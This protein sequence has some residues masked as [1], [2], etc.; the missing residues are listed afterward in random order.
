M[1]RSIARGSPGTIWRRIYSI[2]NPAAGV[3]ITVP[4]PPHRAWQL[5][6]VSVTLTASASAGNR[7]PALTLR[8]A[9]NVTLAQIVSPTAITATLA[10]RVSWVT[11]LGAANVVAASFATLTLP[12]PCYMLSAESLTI[13]GHTDAGDT[14]TNCRVTVIETN[15]G[16][17]DYIGALERGILDHAQAIYEL[18]HEGE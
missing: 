1:L 10:P 2:A 18:V 17:P 12:T 5:L 4:V 7:L 8:D 3:D 11:G 15:T 6:G 13:T 9:S 14:W 16:D